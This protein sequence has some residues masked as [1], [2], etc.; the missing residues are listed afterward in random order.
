MHTAP[1]EAL[2]LTQESHA[3][4]EAELAVHGASDLRRDAYGDPVSLT[5]LAD[6]GDQH[7]LDGAARSLATC[8]FEGQLKGTWEEKPMV[9]K[10]DAHAHAHS[11]ANAWWTMD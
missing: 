2:Y 5:G 9:V 4:R 6:D 1:A 11:N 7:R 3:T 8:Q 10:T